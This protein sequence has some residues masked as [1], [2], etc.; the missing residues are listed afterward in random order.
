MA[1]ADKTITDATDTHVQDQKHK[2]DDEDGAAA[3]VLASAG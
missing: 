2:D 1:G 3:G